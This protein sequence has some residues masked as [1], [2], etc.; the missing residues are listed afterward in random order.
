MITY[1][2]FQSATVI[3]SFALEILGLSQILEFHERLTMQFTLCR[4]L[5]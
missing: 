3:K 1:L 4:Y 5:H 2:D